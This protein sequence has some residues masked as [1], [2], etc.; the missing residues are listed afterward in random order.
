MKKLLLILCLLLLPT[1]SYA[2]GGMMLGIV[3]GGTPAAAGGTGVI[4]QIDHSGTGYGGQTGFYM[5]EAFTTTTAGAVSYG[6]IHYTSTGS[7]KLV[8]SI[9]EHGT[10]MTMLRS[11]ST[12]VVG[13]S[14]WVNIAMTG[15]TGELAAA[16]SYWLAFQTTV[17]GTLGAVNNASSVRYHTESPMQDPAATI[18]DE[19]EGDN[20]KVLA[21]L[22]N[23]TAGSP[24]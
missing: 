3:G 5:F 4:G 24:E 23:N 19:G 15:G 22:F 13:P 11:G 12:T 7:T 9:H 10:P 17:A 14:G 1:L 6:H 18:T 2:G 8:I 20:Y 21:I 16:T